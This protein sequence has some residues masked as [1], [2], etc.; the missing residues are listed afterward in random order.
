MAPTYAGMRGRPL[1]LSIST[2]ATMGFLLF[3]YDRTSF[4]VNPNCCQSV[5]NEVEGVMSG[6]ISDPAFNNVFTA[7]KGDSVMQALVTAVYELGCLVGAIWALIF[8]DWMGRRWMIF[9]GAIVMIIGV[10][11]QVCRRPPIQTR[12]VSQL[13]MND[14][15]P[16]SSVTSPFCNSS[17]GESSRASAMV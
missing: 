4:P 1:A 11:I 8:G 17:S 10:V 9:S 14:R 3:G 7:T 6:I 15:S 5:T 16:R 12:E 2:I 13:T